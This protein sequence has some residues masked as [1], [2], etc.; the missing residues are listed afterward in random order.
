MPLSDIHTR[1]LKARLKLSILGF[2]TVGILVACTEPGYKKYAAMPVERPVVE[3]HYHE[4][5][6]KA[7]IQKVIGERTAMAKWSPQDNRCDVYF[8]AG[9]FESLGHEVYHCYKGTFHEE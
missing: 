1:E 4:F 9:D 5:S 8:M 7:E 6:S 3:L 2:V